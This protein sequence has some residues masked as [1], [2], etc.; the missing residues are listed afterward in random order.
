MRPAAVPAAILVAAMLVVVSG[1]ALPPSL[2]GLNQVLPLTLMLAGVAMSVWYNRGRIFISAAS[3]LVAFSGFSIALT[4]GE[5]SIAARAVFAAMTILVPLN[6]TAGMLLPERGVIHHFNY[7]WLMLAV[8]ETAIVAWIASAGRNALSGLAWSTALDHWLLKSPPMPIAGRL[9]L[10]IA[11]VVSVLCARPPAQD[12]VIRPIAITTPAMLVAFFLA[13]EWATA[14]MAF[15]AYMSAAAAMLLAGLLQESHRLAFR[16]E[17]TGLRSR[18]AMEERLPGLGPSFVVAMV[19]VDHFKKFNDTHGHAIGD[20]VLKLVAA[21]LDEAGGGTLAYRY[22]G[23]EFAVI[24]PDQ[25]IEAALRH[26][27]AIRAAVEGYEMAIRGPDRPKSEQTGSVMRQSRSPTQYLS[28]TVSI[29]LAASDSVDVPAHA[30][31]READAALYRAKE[32]GRN[33]VSV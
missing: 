26:A 23:E 15:N 25:T 31:L 14:P 18:R 11:F 2:A 8:A 28:V 24:F 21:R 7:R 4:Y 30:V 32:A 6:V 10:L 5:S 1:L 16:D 12:P 27:D 33:R 17:L 3:L 19:D 9:A 29:G 20:Q 13:C 22:G